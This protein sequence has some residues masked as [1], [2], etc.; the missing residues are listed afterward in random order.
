MSQLRKAKTNFR[1]KVTKVNIADE[2]KDDDK[3]EEVRQ[4]LKK[5][6]GR[7]N[8]SP[9]EILSL[10]ENFEHVD[11]FRESKLTEAHLEEVCSNL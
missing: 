5:E 6:T 3:M 4:L 11:Y 8:R 10:I 7:E 2:W 9:V 1:R